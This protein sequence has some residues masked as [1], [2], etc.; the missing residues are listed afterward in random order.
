MVG[1]DPVPLLGHR[2]VERAQPG[3][4][5]C[6]PRAPAAGVGRLAG[7]DS[8]GERR[9]GVAVHEHPV[10]PLCFDDRFEAQ[11]HLRGLGAVRAAAHL[12]VDVGLGDL[13]ITEEGGAHRV[14]VVLAGVH[15]HFR[16]GRKQHAADGCGLDELRSGADHGQ[17]FHGR[18]ASP[19]GGKCEP[20]RGQ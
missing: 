2:P 16:V 3:L 8:R 12:E 17:D 7:H 1:D 5:V 6:Q 10:R 20:Q 15:Q 11:D 13:Q 19:T 18:S 9:I 4:D 14:V